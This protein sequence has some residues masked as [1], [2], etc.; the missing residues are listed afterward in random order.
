MKNHDFLVTLASGRRLFLDGAMGTMLQAAGM[1]PAM[2]PEKFCLANPAILKGIHKA[3][4]DAGANIITTCTFGA[5]T[6]KMPPDLDPLSFNKEMAR[7]ARSAVEEK[8]GS[9]PLFVAGN[10]GPTGK[11]AEPL[12]DVPPE[13]LIKAFEQQIRGLAEGGCDLIFMETQ[14]DLAEV[15]AAVVACRNVCNLP[16]MVSMTYEHGLSL[17]GTTPTIFAGTMLNLGCDI[18]GTNCSLGPDEMLPVVRELLDVCSVP[19]MAEPNAGLP[20]LENGKTVFKL[21]PDEFARKTARFAEAGVQILGGCCGTTPAHIA[22]LVKICANIASQAR[23]VRRQ[24]GIVLTSRTEIVRIGNGHPFVIIGERIN[25]T[26]KP[27]LASQIAAGEFHEALA[28][29]AV[30]LEAGASVLDVNVGAPGV[31][32]E[33]TLPKL[34]KLLTGRF[35]CPLALD[36]SSVEAIRSALPVCTGSFLV[37]S[38]SG[39]KDRLERLAP[40]C[41]TYGAP[42]ILLP[43]TGAKLPE[44]A[45]ERIQI[46]EMLLAKAENLDIPHSLI[47]VDALAMSISATPDAARECMEV[48]SWCKQNGLASTCGL[49]NISFGM[50]AR[51]LVNATFLSMSAGAGL[52][53]CIANPGAPRVSEAIAAIHV[54]TG[55]DRNSDRF[56]AMFADWKPEAP[57]HRR[58]AR[59]GDAVTSY[60]AV[61][62]G[63]KEDIIAI[64]EK[65][66]AQGQDPLEL[67]NGSL[68]PAINEVGTLYEKKKYFL[69]QLIRSA[70]TMSLAFEKLKPILAARG[71]DTRKPV[72]VLATVEGDIHD[73]G[74]K[75]VALLLGNHGF[76]VIDAG[77]D[78]PAK[79]I[80]DCAQKYGAS[81]IGLSALM[82][83]T[84]V[85]MRETVDL[86]RAR[87]LNMRVM[88]GGAAVTG[89]FADSIGADGYS[90]DAVAAVKL[91]QS[92]LT[93]EDRVKRAADRA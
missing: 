11:F 57:A 41:R 60:E 21:G 32:Q 76:E 20:V 24:P 17:T 67:I 35:Q 16:V 34:V 26:G 86:V 5:N 22:A 69:P 46:L 2:G 13:A 91:A 63:G 37:N 85:K 4:L 18:I 19:V 72:V 59:T 62:N 40:I 42:F 61:L 84:M 28:L 50:P 89:E 55:Q 43:L 64:L 80:V 56:I 23:A 1:P 65:E 36:S 49:S 45:R 77:K 31:D 93:L 82:T 7:I 88:V 66:L 10:V 78:V 44:T 27:R 92:L 9:S 52:S 68:I 47:L 81:I 48:I 87:G 3:Y 39:E 38:V 74:K 54:L 75:I 6:Y 53:S 33:K 79:E 71:S 25:P 12:G 15:K 83:T 51:D 29:G 58:N 8:G 30:Q 70:E 14:F 90:E 73:I